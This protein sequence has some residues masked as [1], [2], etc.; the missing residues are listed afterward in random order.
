M[1]SIAD[2]A[3]PVSQEM[4]RCRTEF[5]RLL[6]HEN[7]FL[8]DVLS[9]V[10]AYKG[11]MLRPL[12]TLLCGK[13][14]G[15]VNDKTL[16]MAVALEMFHTASLLHDD[17]VDESNERRGNASVNSR[18]GN[19][20]AVLVGDFM[21]ALSLKCVAATGEPRLMSLLSD[22][23]QRMTDGE[24]LQLHGSLILDTSEEDYFRVIEAKTGALFAV[25]TQAAALCA[26]AP[27][28]VV[29]VMR[30]FGLRLGVCFQLKDDVLDYIGG[31]EI[32]KPV[33]NDLLEGKVT[34]PLLY[35]L[36]QQPGGPAIQLAQKLKSERISAEE[37]A[38]L[39]D[40]TVKTGGVEYAERV[41]Q[42]FAAEAKQALAPYSASPVYGNLCA[43]VDYLIERTH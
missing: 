20:S 39:I 37:S 2:L 33:G 26:G 14:L 24:L 11:K 6:C 31:A 34:L 25:C 29:C 7:P 4:T 30:D 38:A 36:K 15:E 35:A 23:A 32:G 10:A 5:S 27:Q 21:L 42:Q 18:F 1:H 43:F 41:M 40:F 16:S 17:I 19:K 13:L 3:A 22:C 12:L 8:D 28:E 9:F